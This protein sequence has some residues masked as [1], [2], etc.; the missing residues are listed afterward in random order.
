[1]IP[2]QEGRSFVVLVVGCN[3]ITCETVGAEWVRCT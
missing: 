1:M 2:E 3:I